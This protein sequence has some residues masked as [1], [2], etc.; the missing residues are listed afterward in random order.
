MVQKGER[1]SPKCLQPIKIAED[2]TNPSNHKTRIFP[3][4]I[5]SFARISLEP[6]TELRSKRLVIHVTELDADAWWW[7][8]SLS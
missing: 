2:S 6:R 1:T 5:T 7:D 4:R 3:E 8:A